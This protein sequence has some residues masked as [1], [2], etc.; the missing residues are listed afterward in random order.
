MGL[1][2]F[3]IVWGHVLRT[4]HFR[5]YLYAFNVTLFFFLLGYTFK[6]G[7]SLKEFLKKRFFRTMIPYYIWAIVSIM[8]F[9][10]M[11]KFLPF[12]ITYAS[13][14]LWKNLIGMFYANS[15]TIYMRW[16]LPLWFIPCMNL[17]LVIAWVIEYMLQRLT[18]IGEKVRIVVCVVFAFIEITMQQLIDI[19]FPFQFESAVLMVAFVE[20][21]LFFKKHKIIEKSSSHKSCLFI[22]RGLLFIGISAAEVNGIAEVRNYHYGKYPILFLIAACA[23]T[24]AVCLI[25]NKIKCNTI[26]EQVGR[27]SFPI[28]L[29][30]KFPILF[31]QSVLPVTKNL[32]EKP[33]T[34]E[35][36]LCS[37]TVSCITVSMCYIGAL[38]IRKIAP[39]IIGE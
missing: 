9:L 28:L 25:S 18:E 37:F 23:M 21:G 14:S 11:G 38:I 3:F 17:T 36:F 2:V 24:W 30:H 39:M 4:G 12:D 10:L 35:G 15:R 6:Y 16:N 13:M 8:I 26:L 5:I 22:V 27:I 33:D 31:F 32:L 7:A 34:V 20:L 29:M 19:K 1:G